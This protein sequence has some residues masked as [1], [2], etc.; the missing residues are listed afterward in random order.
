MRIDLENFFPNIEFNSVQAVYLRAGYTLEVANLLTLLSTELPPWLRLEGNTAASLQS[1][2]ERCL[3]QGAPTSPALSNLVCV[4]L[5]SELAKIPICRYTR[6]ADDLTF[7]LRRS[8][9]IETLREALVFEELVAEVDKIVK[10]HGFKINHEKTLK[11]PASQRQIVAGI[12]VNGLTPRVPREYIRRVRASL[13]EAA[14]HGV[15]A[16]SRETDRNMIEHINGTIAYIDMVNASQ[17]I[18]LW[19]FAIGIDPGISEWLRVPGSVRAVRQSFIDE[20][21]EDGWQKS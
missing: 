9:P 18:K 17:A 2:R 11:M 7:S 21:D 8:S 16:M 19:E 6:Y 13:Y 3:P 15:E 4:S 14:S 5:D 1:Y 10:Q 12:V 20:L